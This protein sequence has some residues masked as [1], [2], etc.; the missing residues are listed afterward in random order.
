MRR[1]RGRKIRNEMGQKEKRNEIERE[2]K[3][4]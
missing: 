2:R 4:K 1:D 3:N